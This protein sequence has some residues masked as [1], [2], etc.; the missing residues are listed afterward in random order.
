M[1]KSLGAFLLL[2]LMVFCFQKARGEDNGTVNG[3]WKSKHGEFKIWTVDGDLLQVEF[4]G[5]YEYDSP[6][7][8]M[9][10][11]GEGSGAATLEN[12]TARFKP[13]GAEEECEILLKF[14]G[15]KLIVTQTGVCGFGN[16]VTA[17]GTYERTSTTEPKFTSDEGD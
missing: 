10:N 8:P 6:Q 1:K 5:S 3:T 13:D 16:K 4:S 9:A 2:G 15:G 7:G 14:A 17:A 12:G 11:T